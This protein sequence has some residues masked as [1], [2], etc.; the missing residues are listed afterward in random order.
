MKTTLWEGID[1]KS[2]IFFDYFFKTEKSEAGKNEFLSGQKVFIAA[3][4]ADFTFSLHICRHR[5]A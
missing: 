5:T 2:A 1:E 4:L 3:R